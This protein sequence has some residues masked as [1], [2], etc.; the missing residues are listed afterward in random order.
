MKYELSILH[1]Y[2]VKLPL[3]CS[4]NKFF[5]KNSKA[6]QSSIPLI[7]LDLLDIFLGSSEVKRKQNLTIK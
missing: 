1:K 3:K 4:F 6:F 5:R 7:V 2:R